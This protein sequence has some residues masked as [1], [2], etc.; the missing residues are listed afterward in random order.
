LAFGVPRYH[1]EGAAVPETRRFFPTIE[2]WAG[3][4]PSGAAI[5]R[6]AQGTDLLTIDAQAGQPVRLNSQKFSAREGAHF[7]AE[8][9]VAASTNVN[10]IG[11][12]AIIFLD[13]TG[14]EIIRNAS[15]IKPSWA[16]ADHTLTDADGAF[17]LPKR[18]DG[19]PRH[20]EKRL[21]VFGSDALR[22]IIQSLPN[23]GLGRHDDDQHH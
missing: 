2:G 8:F 9:S 16:S 12:V 15:R 20:T 18:Q 4:L 23:D 21:Y 5:R 1:E 13:A 7:Q 10:N 17:R 19:A 3:G 14:K 11:Y 22:P 6:S